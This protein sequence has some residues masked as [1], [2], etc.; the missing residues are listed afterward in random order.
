[1]PQTDQK[2]TTDRE[3]FELWLRKTL[4]PKRNPRYMDE[5]D[6]TLK[7]MVDSLIPSRE[8]SDA[9]LELNTRDWLRDFWTRSL[10]TWLALAISIAS[11]II[12]IAAR[13]R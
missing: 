4:F 13:S 6:S 12:A 2:K 11:I 7:H 5:P 8:K 3:K 1:M 9:E 10:V